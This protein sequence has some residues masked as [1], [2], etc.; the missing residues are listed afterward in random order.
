MVLGVSSQYK[1]LFQFGQLDCFSVLLGK[2]LLTG[3]VV[4]LVL[5]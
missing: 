1:A 4:L 5:S 3:G 2:G